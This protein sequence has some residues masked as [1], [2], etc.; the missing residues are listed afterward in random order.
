MAQYYNSMGLV[1]WIKQKTC[2]VM[3][4]VFVLGF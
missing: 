4:K 3:K 1:K 2:G